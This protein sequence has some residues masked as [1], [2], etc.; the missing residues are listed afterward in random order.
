MLNILPDQKV[1]YINKDTLYL[2]MKILRVIASM[3][4]ASGGPCQGIR[5]LIPEL[6]KLGINNEVVS[7]DAPSANFLRKDPFTIIPLG[8]G[9][10]PWCYNPSLLTWL[11]SN[12]NRF[13]IIIVHGLWLYHG[14]A[15][16]KAIDS[17]RNKQKENSSAGKS[18]KVFV[19]PHGMLD[20]Y[21]QRASGRT[22]KAIRNWV[23]W[24]LMESR[25]INNTA[26]G[27]LF[28]CEEELRLARK[29]FNPYHPKRELNVGY[30]ITPPP[31]FDDK[32]SIDF[33]SKCPQIKGNR[34]ILF[35]SRLHQKKGVDILIEAYRQVARE[36][37]NNSGLF[38]TQLLELPKLVIAGPGLDTTYGQELQQVVSKDAILSSSVFFAGMLTGYAKWGAFYGS[39][40]F[41]LPS[42]QENFGIAVVEALA[43]SKAVL[44][45][46]Q[47]N[48]WRE[49]KADKAGLISRDTIDGIKQ[50]LETWLEL[51]AEE[52]KEMNQ[53][54]R[55][56]FEKNF[57][58][59]G[60]AKQLLEVLDC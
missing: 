12:I 3:D 17:L 23:Y 38:K 27:L 41:V 52:K 9:K 7:L 46:D 18:P 59:S 1:S 2:P 16:R 55:V 48:I 6:E 29:A 54:A 10:G 34:Y 43:C 11:K 8:C 13:D 30:G 25:L 14:S 28:T 51:S 20:P 39:E 57:S 50:M 15:V 53:N 26:E 22:L 37:V 35:L 21:F 31:A 45:S 32:M 58:V 40:L 42:H 33:L 49:I 24:K 4:P 36:R 44:I 60:A 47:V 5:N 56:S 19:M